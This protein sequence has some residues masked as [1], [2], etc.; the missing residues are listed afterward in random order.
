MA[1]DQEM[2]RAKLHAARASDATVLE[3]F[4]AA[5]AA[6]DIIPPEPI[7]ADGRL[8]RCDA[9]G[10]RGHGDAAY[11]LHLDGVPTGGIETIDAAYHL[12]MEDKIGSI[13]DGKYADF[14]V[15]SADPLSHPADRLLETKVIYTVVEGM[16]VI[17]A[18]NRA[19][20]ATDL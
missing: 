17:P 2:Q 6:R 19:S 13:E 12:R 7:I 11:L 15:L 1:N 16:E 18:A 10:P 20:Q 9:V 4:R 14:V 3:Q 8:H 5:L